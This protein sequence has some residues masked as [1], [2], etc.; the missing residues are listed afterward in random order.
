MDNAA[1]AE[2][3]QRAQ[4]PRHARVV[5]PPQRLL[6]R[7]AENRPGDGVARLA[8][9]PDGEHLRRQRGQEARQ[10][11]LAL[12]ECSLQL[13]RRG[14]AA[15]GKLSKESLLVTVEWIHEYL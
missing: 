1:V 12:A 14:N 6:G 2:Q 15:R 4:P 11:R 13:G 3:A 5:D 10:R 7:L 8:A 9:A